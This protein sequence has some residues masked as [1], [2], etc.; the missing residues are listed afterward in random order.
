MKLKK[1]FKNN[2]FTQIFC[3]KRQILKIVKKILQKLLQKNYLKDF[4]KKC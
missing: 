2:L 3:K 1:N 4:Q